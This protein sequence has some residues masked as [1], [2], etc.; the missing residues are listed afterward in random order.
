MSIYRYERRLFLVIDG[1]NGI[2]ASKDII[3]ENKKKLLEYAE[4]LKA[5]GKSLPRQVKLLMTLKK[6]ATWLGPIS[7]KKASEKDMISVLAKVEGSDHTRVDF[8]KIKAV[9]RLAL[10]YQGSTTQRIS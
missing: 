4:Y 1:P 10:S 9:L 5:D 3:R 6:I 7:F 2:K 8:Q